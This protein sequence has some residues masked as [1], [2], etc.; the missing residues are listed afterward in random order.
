MNQDI[1]LGERGKKIS[2][3]LKYGTVVAVGFAASFIVVQAALGL[4]GLAVI[5]GGIYAV[6]L[7]SPVISLKLT[8]FMMARFIE[9]VWKNPVLTRRN[10]EREMQSRLAEEEKD[11]LTQNAGVTDF[12]QKVDGLSKKFPQDAEKFRSQLTMFK[13]A[14]QEQYDD[15]ARGQNALEV[16]KA[17]T[18]RVEAIWSVCETGNKLARKSLNRQRRDAMLKIASD[19]AIKASE[20]SLA[21]TQARLDHNRRLRKSD[22]FLSL[23]SNPSPTMNAEGSKVLVERVQ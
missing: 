16:Y 22:S 2:T 11:L 8:N 20:A 17:E 10:I 3:F 14:L 18:E 15:L 23:E 21:M 19:E 9:E 12:E 6:S 7:F 5:I 13:E 4:I 1:Q